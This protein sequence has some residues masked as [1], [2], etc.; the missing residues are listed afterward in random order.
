MTD[1]ARR[2]AEPTAWPHT[3]TLAE[4]AAVGLD[5]GAA[6]EMPT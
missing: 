4:S 3:P 5:G 2:K 6:G 1:L